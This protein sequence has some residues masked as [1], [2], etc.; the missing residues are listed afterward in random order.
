MGLT[1]DLL[2]LDSRGDVFL[3]LISFART[4]K[5][6]PTG[7]DYILHI[8]ITHTHMKAARNHNLKEGQFYC[9]TNFY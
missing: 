6:N 8:N 9:G 5:N 3:S 2:H 4:C 7:C 1:R